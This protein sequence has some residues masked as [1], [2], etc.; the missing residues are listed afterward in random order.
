MHEVF[1]ACVPCQSRLS[2]GHEPDQMDNPHPGRWL[3]LSMREITTT[4][5]WPGLSGGWLFD[6]YPNIVDNKGVQ[7]DHA[8][9]GELVGA[10]LSS[11]SSRFKRPLSSLSFAA[12]YLTGGLDPRGWRL[13]NLLIH[14]LN[15]VLVFWLARELLAG[16]FGERA[17]PPPQPSP[18]SGG[19]SY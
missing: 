6:D 7:P 11:P 5:Y 1:A 10:A 8:S 18:A 14:L 12:N 2:C 4:V 17:D 15:G 9:V 3:L 19:G 16:V 13:V